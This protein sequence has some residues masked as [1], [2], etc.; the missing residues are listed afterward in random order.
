MG[1]CAV[2]IPWLPGVRVIT[3][4]RVEPSNLL[5]GGEIYVNAPLSESGSLTNQGRYL[6]LIRPCLSSR[7]SHNATLLGEPG[8][9]NRQKL[10]STLCS[11]MEPLKLLTAASLVLALAACAGMMKTRECRVE[12]PNLDAAI[13]ERLNL[14]GNSDIACAA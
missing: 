2:S 13:R 5:V 8:R 11:G 9:R 3:F 1:I 12:A 10:N 14:S 4:H 7:W 6:G